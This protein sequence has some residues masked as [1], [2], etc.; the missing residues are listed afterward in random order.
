MTL[1]PPRAY[2]FN[3][4]P[5]R[6]LTMNTPEGILDVR[7]AHGGWRGRLAGWLLGLL[8]LGATAVAH[9]DGREE[10]LRAAAH[11]LR[12]DRPE[13]ADDAAAASLGTE[14]PGV[15]AELL[16]ALAWR[17]TGFDPTVRT[18]RVCGA[19]QV[20]P[21]DVDEPDARDA[22]LRWSQDTWQGFDAGA[23]ELVRW[24]RHA[25]GDLS[26]ALRGR[27]C[28]WIGLT[29]S[30]GKDDW[31]RQVIRLAGAIRRGEIR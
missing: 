4:M 28:G 22:C 23:E 17:E 15:S 16:L 26:V 12:P 5:T 9:A 19:L 20:V 14:R 24:L 31:V 18:G 29:R 30:C 25:R 10:R 27:A 2:I 3:H 7:R 6:Y 21:A 8:A 1:G 13:L 11:R